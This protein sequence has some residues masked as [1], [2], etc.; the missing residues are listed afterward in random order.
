MPFRQFAD[1][2]RVDA[3]D[4][5]TYVMNQ[6]IPT[7]ATST[8]RDASITSPQN[9]QHA[10]IS[11]TGALTAFTGSGWMIV[12]QLVPTWNPLSLSAGWV[13]HSTAEA[14]GYIHHAGWVHLKGTVKKSS[15]NIAISDHTPIAAMPSD[16]LPQKTWHDLGKI[17]VGDGDPPAA[18]VLISTAGSITCFVPVTT[19]WISLDGIRF[20][21]A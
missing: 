13:S 6:V 17:S 14:P 18:A 10:Y 9:G 21:R 5:M 3:D 4:W 7:F 20:P 16:V 19:A 8:E 11:G 2:E 15:G 1:L 12:Y